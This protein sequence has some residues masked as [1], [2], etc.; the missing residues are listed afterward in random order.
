MIVFIAGT[1]KMCH[2][3][4]CTWRQAQRSNPNITWQRIDTTIATGWV[5]NRQRERDV[6]EIFGEDDPIPLCTHC[7]C[8]F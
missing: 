5:A 6:A 3:E 7:H 2:T 8:P 1:A 4:G